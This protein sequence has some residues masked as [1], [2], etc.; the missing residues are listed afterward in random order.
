[1]D[2][3][4]SN[5]KNRLGGNMVMMLILGGTNRSCGPLT[6]SPFTISAPTSNAS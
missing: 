3:F 2:H 4:I 1:M 6:M 5:A